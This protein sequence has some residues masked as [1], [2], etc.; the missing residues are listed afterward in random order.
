VL[1]GGRFGVLGRVWGGAHW[2]G[3]Q[4]GTGDD[5]AERDEA[6]SDPEWAGA[7]RF[8]EDEDAADDRGEVGGD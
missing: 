5:E 1:A 7:D 8:V 3:H 6:G 4:R 2:G